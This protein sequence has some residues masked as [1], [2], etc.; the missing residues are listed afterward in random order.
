MAGPDVEKLLIDK[1]WRDGNI[2]G[3]SISD[4]RTTFCQNKCSGHGI[5]NTETRACMCETFWMPDIF[6]FWGVR[7]ANCG[8]FN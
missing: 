7:Q 4:I 1:F 6:Y 2:L 3:T 8:N 5:C